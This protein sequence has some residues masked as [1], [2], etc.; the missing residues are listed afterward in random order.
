M[1]RVLVTESYISDI[2]S[3]IR[4]KNGQSASYTPSQMASAINSIISAGALSIISKSIFS[5]GTYSAE[6]DNADAFSSVVVDVPNTYTAGDEGKVVSGG[7]L[8]AQGSMSVSSNST[9]D[10]TSYSQ[11]VV[12]V[13][14]ASM[15][16]ISKTISQNGTYDPSD[17]SADAYSQVVVNVAGGGGDS[18]I[19]YDIIL[20]TG[21]GSISISTISS[22]R[23]YVCSNN[24]GVTELTL[25]GCEYIGANAFYSCKN[26]SKISIPDCLSF[27][28]Q[29]FGNCSSLISIYAPSLNS[30]AR[31]GFASCIGL[32][33]VSLPNVIVLGAYAFMK[34]YSLKTVSFPEC[35]SIGGSCFAFCSSLENVYIPRVTE[36]GMT[37]FSGCSKLS[38][39]NVQT[40]QSL[41]DRAFL[42]CSSLESISLP[43]CKYVGG[44]AFAGCINLSA[45]YFG[46]NIKNTAQYGF[47]GCFNLLSVYFTNPSV[48]NN[49]YPNMF[50]S[51]PISN[52]T[53]STG[54]VYGSIYVPA[55]LVDAYKTATQWSAFADRFTSIPE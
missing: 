20:G 40:C 26:M 12:D 4:S 32:S 45:V 15:S 42:G 17:D 54:G 34:C 1:A 52:Y 33:E 2:A 36:I 48:I 6:G 50:T 38:Q 51:T 44:Y 5:N 49:Q 31:S 43:E 9:Y 24:S 8:I 46:S 55:S 47:S 37:A 25:T 22:F 27:S 30:V 10:T 35:L 23:G 7:S 3:A 53:V 39:I 14:S 13:P 18:N 16:F 19:G 21:T 29:T 11:I 28:D 41:Y